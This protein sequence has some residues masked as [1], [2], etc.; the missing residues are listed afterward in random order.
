MINIVLEHDKEK[1]IILQQF[2]P[3]IAKICK[4]LKKEN[5]CK[6]SH[7]EPNFEK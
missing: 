7:F 3:K 4:R 6:T 1:K 2:I 5:G